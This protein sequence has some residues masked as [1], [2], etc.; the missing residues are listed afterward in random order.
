VATL[1]GAR[2][3]RQMEEPAPER[4]PAGHENHRRGRT[5][6]NQPKH[7]ELRRFMSGVKLREGGSSVKERTR[8]TFNRDAFCSCRTD[9]RRQRHWRRRRHV[10]ERPFQCA[11]Q[12]SADVLCCNLMVA[13][14]RSAPIGPFDL[15]GGPIQA[16][17]RTALARLRPP[18]GLRLRRSLALLRPGSRTVPGKAAGWCFAFMR[19]PGRPWSR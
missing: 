11:R 14:W 3:D 18:N 17:P 19:A 5:A 13:V 9:D 12:D 8:T 7:R 1:P 4:Q 15:P 10:L 2:S 16:L 6:A